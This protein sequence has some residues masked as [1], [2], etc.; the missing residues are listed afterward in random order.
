MEKTIKLEDKQAHVL[1]KSAPSDLGECGRS[2]KP[3][4]STTHHVYQ[5]AKA[6]TIITIKSSNQSA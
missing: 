2:D 3:P 1:K 4:E 6:I 5:T